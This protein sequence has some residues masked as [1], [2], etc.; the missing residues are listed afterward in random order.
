MAAQK[1]V[2]VG[3]K[4]VELSCYVQELRIRGDRASLTMYFA[5]PD[6]TMRKKLVELSGRHRRKFLEVIIR[7]RADL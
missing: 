2:P 1:K 4:K 6:M 3:R 5:D 7:E